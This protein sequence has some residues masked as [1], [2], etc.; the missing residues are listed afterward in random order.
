MELLLTLG[1]SDECSEVQN[2]TAKTNAKGD[3]QEGTRL[4]GS[5]QIP[6]VIVLEGRSAVEMAS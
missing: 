4:K 1:R 5:M 6:T 3:E 2:I